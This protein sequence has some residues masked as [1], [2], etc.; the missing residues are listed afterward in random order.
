[1]ATQAQEIAYPSL[2][3]QAKVL[4][5][6]WTTAHSKENCFIVSNFSDGIIV[7]DCTFQSYIH[8]IN[9]IIVALST[10]VTFKGN[11]NLT[12]NMTGIHSLSSGTA[13]FLRTTHPELKSS[14]N[15]TIGATV[16][17]VNLTC[18]NHGAAVLWGEWSDKYWC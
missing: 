14:L 7:S 12:D 6:Y 10:V 4:K 9:S 1:M 11:V 5:L 2:I 15:V 13:V 16:Y 17:F 3:S 18:S 8:Q